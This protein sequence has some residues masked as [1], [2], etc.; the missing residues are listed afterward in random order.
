[1]IAKSRVPARLDADEVEQL[2]ARHAAAVVDVGLLEELHGTATSRLSI[3][4][5]A[6]VRRRS[7][8]RRAARRRGRGS[9]RAPTTG[10][11]RRRPGRRFE[12]RGSRISSIHSMMVL[13]SSSSTFFV[14]AG[15]VPLMNVGR[16]DRL[17]GASLE[18]A[19]GA[20][21]TVGTGVGLRDG[22]GDGGAVVGVAVT[23]GFGV[24]AAGV[25][26]RPVGLAVVGLT[27]GWWKTSPPLTHMWSSY[28]AE[29]SRKWP[30]TS[31][32]GSAISSRRCRRRR[33]SRSSRRRGRAS[34]RSRSRN[35]ACRSP[36]RRRRHRDVGVVARVVHAVRGARRRRRPR[37]RG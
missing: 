19:V 29:K 37:R 22:D 4:M 12:S 32:M 13:P 16:G 23:V 6:N 25:G 26:G 11:T 20:G 1:M 9:C 33:R 35:R 30:P 24:C 17:G 31:S 21:V 28:G 15:V 18:R 7:A 27:V 34:R 10:R 5:K 8:S 2:G 36:H 14:G 3:L